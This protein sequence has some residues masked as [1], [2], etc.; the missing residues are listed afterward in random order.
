MS[1]LCYG[2]VE[3]MLFRLY[4][5]VVTYAVSYTGRFADHVGPSRLR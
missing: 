5:R 2:L 4:V 1:Y 3:F